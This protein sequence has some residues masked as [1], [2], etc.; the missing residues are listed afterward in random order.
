[1]P[2][3]RSLHKQAGTHRLVI[4]CQT[5]YVLELWDKL[6]G[7]HLLFFTLAIKP[8]LAKVLMLFCTPPDPVLS[9]ASCVTNAVGTTS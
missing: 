7:V 5:L 9:A 8:A 6:S 4:L 2:D 3:S 1:M